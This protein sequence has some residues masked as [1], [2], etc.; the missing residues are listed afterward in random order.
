[1]LGASHTLT[2]SGGAVTFKVQTLADEEM[3][4]EEMVRLSLVEPGGVLNAHVGVVTL[5]DGPRLVAGVAVSET[6]LD[7]ME[8]GV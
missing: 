7:L 6:A 1:M 8:W 4:E 5:R 2:P 3:E